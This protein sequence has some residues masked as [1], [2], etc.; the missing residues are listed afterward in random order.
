MLKHRSGIFNFTNAQDY[1]SWMEQPITK[2]ELVKKITEYGSVFEPNEK[3]EYSNA[4]YVLLS[5]IAEKIDGNEFAIILNKRI[6]ET[7][8]LSNTYYGSK[9]SSD[10]NEAQSYTK[11]KDWKIATETDMSIPV[12]AGA[13]VSNPTDLNKFLNALFTGKIVSEQSLQKM[14]EIQDGIGIGM[15]QIPFYDKKAFGHG[16]GI[17]GFQSNAFYF[18]NEKVSVSYTS[19]GVFMPM[20]DILIGILSIY[21]GREY[22]FP[23]FTEAL[24]LESE[25]LDKYLGVYS[26]PTFPLKITITKKENILIGQ[27]TGQSSFPLEAYEIDKFKFDQAVLKIEFKPSEAKMILRQGGGEFEL[28]KE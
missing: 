10:K 25:E 1:Q 7:N 27:A 9:I 12:G 17:D 22:E 23:V 5:Y 28:T 15:F 18:P 19:N 21:F 14:M 3:N 4:N 6:C 2:D 11:L 16:G 26:S 13:I 8:A 20:N 24:Q